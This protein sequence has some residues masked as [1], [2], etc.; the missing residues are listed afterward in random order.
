MIFVPSKDGISH[1]PEEY[2]DCRDI[3]RG[4]DILAET[5]LRLAQD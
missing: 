2:T 1:S 4:T 3:A 5:L